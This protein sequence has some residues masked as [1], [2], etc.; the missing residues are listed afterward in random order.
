PPA[1]PRSPDRASRLLLLF[2]ALLG[3]GGLAL[4]CLLAL[5]LRGRGRRRRDRVATTSAGGWRSGWHVAGLE[6]RQRNRE[7]LRVLVVRD[8]QLGGA[9]PVGLV[10]RKERE[11]DRAG[12]RVGQGHPGAGVRADV[13]VRGEGTGH[14]EG[15]DLDRRSV[16]VREGE[17]L[18]SAGRPDRLDQ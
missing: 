11:V 18:R 3:R 2:L 9:G 7:R 1:R 13:E 6:S 10:L 17:G 4:L 16:L 14:R 8:Q 5:L 12:G 15:A